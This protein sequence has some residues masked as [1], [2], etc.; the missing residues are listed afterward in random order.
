MSPEADRVESIFAAA[1]AKTSPE[2][3]ATYLAE[4]CADDDALRQRVDALLRA[5]D[6]ASGA[7]FLT[8]PH[9]PA[10][11]PPSE[12][13]GTRIGPYKLLQKI[14]EGGMGVVYMADQEHPVRRRVALKVIKP[15]MDS[16]QVV[17]RFEAERQAL[18]LMD[19][20]NIARVLDAG[21]TD[22][23][24]PFFVME[25]VKGVP[26]TKFCDDDRL[27]PRGR[28]ELFVP[29]CQALQHA[30][31]KGI[32]HRDVK[33]SNVLVTLYDGKPVPKVIDFGVAKAL[34]QPLTE[35][36]MFTA[37]GTAVGTLEYMSPE[38]AEVNALDVDTR[39]DVYSL[40][41]LLYEL[42]TGT[43]PLT[44]QRLREAAYAEVL[45]LIR[46]EEPPRPSTR[47]TQSGEEL[48]AISARRQTEPARLAKLLRGELDWIVM[49]ALEKDRARRYEAASGLARDVERYLNDEAVEACP[50]SA[51]YRLRKFARKNRALLTTATAFALLLAVGVGAVTWQVAD[52]RRE[53]EAAAT[54]AR[55]ALQSAL[56]EAEAALKADRPADVDTAL[57]QADQRQL[58]ADAHDLRERLASVKKDREMV[59]RLEKILEQRWSLSAKE[60]TLDASG[61]K[62]Q[63]A[64]AFRGYGLAVGDEPAEAI[65]E[66]VRPSRIAGV[67]IDGLG[68]WFFLDPKQP[69]LQTLLD[70]LDPNPFRSAVREALAADQPDRLR[71]LVAKADG[72]QWT[73]GFAAALG[74]HSALPDPERR[75]ILQ[76]AW[77]SHPNSFSLA[78]TMSLQPSGFF[79]S[80]ESAKE[81]AGW[82]R[83]A[84][85]LRP[86]SA[87]AYFYLSR[88]LWGSKDQ[89]GR[90]RALR[91]VVQLA[92]EFARAHALLGT[93]LV[94]KGDLDDA[95]TPLRKAIELDP[96]NRTTHSTM[97]VALAR[98]GDW[99]GAAESLRRA[100]ASLPEGR[101]DTAIT[102][103]NPDDSYEEG[104]LDGVPQILLTGSR[105]PIGLMQVGRPME[106]FRF[107][108]E[109]RGLTTSD[110]FV[111]SDTNSYNAA[112]AAALA[113]SGQGLD[114]PPPAERPAVR[115]QGLKWL[116]ADLAAWRKYAA[117][118]P[119][120]KDQ[121]THKTM[122]HWLTDPDLTSVR[123]EAEL[124]KLPGEE[125]AKWQHLWA[126]VKSLRERTRPRELLPPPAGVK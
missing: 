109:L 57:D 28:L 4:A 117:A 64:E 33:P 75:R 39:S 94:S 80:R 27:T 15:G 91:K 125:R 66:A 114:A 62:A 89:D 86:R 16:A 60:R 65:A 85:A 50:P 22:S 123:D 121:I 19:H 24:R 38:Q 74:L 104:F 20:P 100:R 113:S 18:A 78:L 29:V 1:L 116:T 40:G 61:A 55:Q 99:H 76:T 37:F 110:D 26:L 95:L 73:P 3:R 12:G 84:I 122:N 101:V 77:D 13:P 72:T 17:A 90:V 23:G 2:E 11:A 49:K 71:E 88:A 93:A 107:C 103:N 124:A 42:L 54:K 79:A 119:V 82:C 31:Q 81:L 52:R 87:V 5:S 25:L 51:G 96:G 43:T 8:T 70:K 9:T 112:C 44:R 32:I 21:T 45:R 67:L 34:H 102:D 108:Q 58:D 97:A 120:K 41:V 83:T 48:P 111:Y 30:H 63:Y 56:D 92:P 126:D 98:K 14:G 46:E 105:I 118:D 47:L 53:R 10:A 59:R 115:Q 35:R 36:T 6:E 7:S 69:G 68:E 106:A